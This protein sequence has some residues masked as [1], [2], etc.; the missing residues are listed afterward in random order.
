MIVELRIYHCAP[1]RLPALHD[2]FTSATLGFFKKHGIEQIG[3][4]TTLAGPTN[5]SL[6]YLLK[7]ESLAERERKWNAF[8]ADPD[9][10]AKRAASEAEKIIVERVENQFLA[11]TAYSALK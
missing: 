7:W 2:R 10:I 4:W 11:P 6:T 5:Q 9:W 8:Q 1:G 3:F